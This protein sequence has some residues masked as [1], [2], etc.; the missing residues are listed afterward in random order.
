MRPTT[1]ERAGRRGRARRRLAPAGRLLPWVLA[2]ALISPAPCALAETVYVTERLQAGLHQDTTLDSTI[3]ETVPTGTPLVVLERRGPFTRVRTPGGAT[4]WID[5]DYLTREPPAGRE[6]L[7]QAR[8]EIAQLRAT[9]AELRQR[10][11]ELEQQRIENPPEGSAPAVTPDALREMQRVAEENRRLKQALAER[12]ADGEPSQPSGFGVARA[13][14]LWHWV[15]LIVVLLIAF[16]LGAY[17]MD[18]RVRRR[19]GGFRV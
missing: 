10:A 8:D 15:F 12:A 13:L 9:V 11:T 2:C 5:A 18:W 17:L 4:G 1:A 16:V 3:L 14:G 19:A 7:R 6:E